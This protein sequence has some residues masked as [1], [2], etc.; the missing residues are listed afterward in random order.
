MTRQTGKHVAKSHHTCSGGNQ[1]PI[2]E[3][4]QNMLILCFCF[5]Q[6]NSYSEESLHKERK[7]LKQPTTLS[8]TV[9]QVRFVSVKAAR[10]CHPSRDNGGRGSASQ[11]GGQ[12]GG[13]VSQWGWWGGGFSTTTRTLGRPDLKTQLFRIALTLCDAHLDCLFFFGSSMEK[14][15]TVP[16]SLDTHTNDES[17]LKLILQREMTKA[18]I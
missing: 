2:P 14:I 8:S 3:K 18:S 15:C 7:S 5:P 10:P 12:L 17:W 11:G 6:N 13:G 9:Q 4:T 1:E 16:W